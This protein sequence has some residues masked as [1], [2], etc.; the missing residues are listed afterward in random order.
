MTIDYRRGRDD[1]AEGLITL[2]EKCYAGYEG[3]VLDVDN[4]EPQLR[5]IKTYFEG[6]GGEFW[7]AEKEGNVVGCIGYKPVEGGVEIK[8]LY[9]DG[10]IRRQGLGT[11]LCDLVEEAAVK[12]KC[13]KIVLWTDTRFH[14]AHSLYERRGFVGKTETRE[15]HDLSKSV[16]YYY[17]KTLP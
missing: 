14:E 3:C 2:I 5:H 16:E 10:D 12:R 7:V 8:H 17:E 9:V 6:L 15:L 11:T 4:E 13:E 1:D